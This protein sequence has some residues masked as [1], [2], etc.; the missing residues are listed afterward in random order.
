MR[1]GIFG[2]GFGLYG[3]LPAVAKITSGE[4]LT[5]ER[6]RPIVDARADLAPY[7]TRLRFCAKDDEI[8][9]QCSRLIV[10]LKPA[11]QDAMLQRLL[12]QRW[13]GRL[14]LE[15]PLAP[16]PV[17]AAARFQALERAGIHFEMG[18]TLAA[19]TWWEELAQYIARSAPD[20][21]TVQ[22]RWRFEAH[23]YRHGISS[24]K[25]RW[26]E[27]GGALRFYGI[28][29]IAA[30]ARYGDV[31]AV[32]CIRELSAA[33][34]EPRCQ[35]KVKGHSFAAD[36][37]CDTVW[38]GPP[39]FSVEARGPSRVGFSVQLADP[40]LESPVVGKEGESDKR[41]CYLGKILAALETETS[42]SRE[43]YRRHLSLWHDLEEQSRRLP[44][45]APL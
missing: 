10:A 32:A 42:S 2:G 13:C 7:R 12:V 26:P 28:H 37:E 17:R 43:W 29:L 36:V 24:W 27:G 1:Y 25:R 6:Y 15:K 45:D 33:G 38:A 19:T 21:V 34:E 31:T 44:P 14:I 8:V 20:A 4:I 39:E 23:H 35:F 40:L 30:L 22:I 41:V 16:D 3:Y 9:N 5:R 11:D 18:F